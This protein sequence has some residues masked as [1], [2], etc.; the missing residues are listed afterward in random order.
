AIVTAPISKTSWMLAGHT[1]HPG[2]TELLADRFDA[3]ESGM[4]FVGP[5]MRVMLATIH[6]PLRDVP[7]GLTTA[8]VLRAIRLA[9][10]SCLDFGVKSPKIGVCGVNPHAGEGGIL[11]TE[12]EAVITPAVAAARA[13]GIGA[14]GPHPAD[15]I[16]SQAVLPPRGPG[17][18]DAIVAMY[19]D[20]GLIPIKLLDK[21]EA[22]N[23]TVGLPTIRTSPAHGTA[24][25]IA[26]TGRADPASMHAAIRTALELLDRA[27]VPRGR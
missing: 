22:V 2:H 16:F 17:A 23:V 24:F 20:Q 7:R 13:L 14:T 25:D 12:D 15:T 27:D 11:G 18:L 6:V 4:L 9:H 5:S 1:R 3:P 10:Q 8:L 19:H 21:R 26:G